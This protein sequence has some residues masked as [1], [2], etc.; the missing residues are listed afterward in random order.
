MID[1]DAIKKVLEHIIYK[2]YVKP[3]SQFMSDF[4]CKCDKEGHSNCIK[5]GKRGIFGFKECY[6]ARNLLHLL[7]TGEEMKKP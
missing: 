2:L 7:Y 1:S 6:T 3:C 4:T 5:Y